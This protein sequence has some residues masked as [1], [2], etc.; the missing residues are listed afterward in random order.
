VK[1]VQN[2]NASHHSHRALAEDK[3]MS[4][5]LAGDKGKV[6]ALHMLCAVTALSLTIASM[7]ATR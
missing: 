4:E 6:A 2:K 1:T 5:Y 7:R 3:I